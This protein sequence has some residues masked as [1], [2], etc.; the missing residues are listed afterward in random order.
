MEMV[1]HTS[2]YEIQNILMESYR[3]IYVHQ[4]RNFD[5]LYYK[6]EFC[7]SVRPSVRPSVRLSAP[8]PP[9]RMGRN[10]L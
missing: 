10:S 7:S 2:I 4:L 1:Y 5:N 6:I 9:G 3:S 8:R